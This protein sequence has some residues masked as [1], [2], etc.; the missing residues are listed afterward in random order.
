MLQNVLGVL[1]RFSEAKHKVEERPSMLLILF[2]GLQLD[3][4]IVGGNWIDFDTKKCTR[5]N[6]VKYA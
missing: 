4:W 5:R 2:K 6:V 3:E 1:I